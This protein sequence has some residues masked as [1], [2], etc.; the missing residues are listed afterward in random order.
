MRCS[1]LPW[2]GALWWWVWWCVMWN[3]QRMCCYG[4]FYVAAWV[5][6]FSYQKIAQLF[7]TNVMPAATKQNKEVQVHQHTMVPIERG[8]DWSVTTTEKKWDFGGR[9]TKDRHFMDTNLTGRSI[10]ECPCWLASFGIERYDEAFLHACLLAVSKVKDIAS[11]MHRC[12]HYC[13][14]FLS[15]TLQCCCHC[16]ASTS[17]GHWL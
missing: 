4:N 15:Q 12:V 10:W 1:F 3:Y 5:P 17:W 8:E 6:T 7:A 13:L 9:V 2:L 11:K 14:F 16:S